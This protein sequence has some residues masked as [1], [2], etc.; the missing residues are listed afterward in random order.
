MIGKQ[1]RMERIM[2]RD[3]GRTVIVPMDHGVT[4]GPIDGLIDMKTTVNAV[5]AGGWLYMSPGY[6]KGFD[7]PP[8]KAFGQQGEEIKSAGEDQP[9]GTQRPRVLAQVVPRLLH[10]I[11]RQPEHDRHDQQFDCKDDPA[12]VGRIQSSSSLLWPGCCGR[13]LTEP[14]HRPKVSWRMGRRSAGCLA[15]SGDPRRTWAGYSQVG[16]SHHFGSRRAVWQVFSA[17]FRENL[18]SA[19]N[20]LRIFSL[21]AM[22]DLN[23]TNS[24]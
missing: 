15:G 2:N 5:A 13:S 14:R 9:V 23:P 22:V 20:C 7:L 18:L 24:F 4:V 21:R 19:R 3:T 6:S 12:A 17:A 10:R 16:S 11:P 1:I 8:L